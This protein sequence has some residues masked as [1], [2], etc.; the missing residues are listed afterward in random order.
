MKKTRN[1]FTLVELLVVIAII[2]ILIALLLPAVQAAREA[3]RRMQCANHLKQLGLA[4]HGHLAT[5]GKLPPGRLGCDVYVAAAPCSLAEHPANTRVG[6]SAF[7]LMLPFL[8]QQPLYEDFSKTDFINGPWLTQS[9]AATAWI[10]DFAG[11]I[12]ERPSV[13]VCP[14]DN[15]EPCCEPDSGGYVAGQKHL[16][17]DGCAATGNYAMSGG[18]EGPSSS[19]TPPSAYWHEIPKFLNS[20][21]FRYLE[22]LKIRDI[23]D[24]TSTTILFGEAYDVASNTGGDLVWSLAYRFTSFRFTENPI[25]TPPGTKFGTYAPQ[26]GRKYNAPFGSR[27]PGGAQFAFA[28]GHVAFLNEEIQMDVYQALSTRNGGESFAGQY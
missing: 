12:A 27:H 14:S 1:A 22:G 9:P 20:G 11:A 7:V 5:H 19:P 26:Y 25:N 15:S 18:P 13:F 28:D 10:P 8:E 23:P 21:A 3:A 6:V 16:Y 17:P 4:A 2:G 24:G